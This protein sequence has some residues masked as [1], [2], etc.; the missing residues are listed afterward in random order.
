[1]RPHPDGPARVHQNFPYGGMNPHS[2]AMGR[3]MIVES[4]DDILCPVGGWENSPSSFLGRRE[5]A[6]L[7]EGDQIIIEEAGKNIVQE[8][9]VV[10]VVLDEGPQVPAIGQVA[11]A[12]ARQGQLDS[13]PAHFFQKEDP[14]SH[15]CGPSRR[16]QARSPSSNYDHIPFQILKPLATEPTEHTEK[17]F[18]RR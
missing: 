5:T 11:P 14:P 15:L 13:D 6:G 9:S 2:Y 12:L 10:P 7:E 8:F 17:F 4:P 16:H 3:D 18:T 1:M